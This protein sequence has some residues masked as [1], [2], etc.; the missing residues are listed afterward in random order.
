MARATEIITMSMREVDRLKVIQAVVDG[1]LKP[2]C[3]AERL[4]LTARKIRRPANR[5]RL[6]GAAGL[7]SRRRGQPS[8][9]RTSA[10]VAS[11]ALDVIRR[12]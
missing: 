1:N 11:L 4:G 7:A 6:E 8:N 12:R 9:N 5:V 3:A 10:E 2:G